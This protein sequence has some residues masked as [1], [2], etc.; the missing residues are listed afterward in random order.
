MNTFVVGFI[1]GMAWTFF[2][3]WLIGVSGKLL[4]PREASE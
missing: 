2:G 1:A 4:D 3:G